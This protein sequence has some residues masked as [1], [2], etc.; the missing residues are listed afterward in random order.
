MA[1]T[2]LGESISSVQKKQL[3]AAFGCIESFA[4]NTRLRLTALRALDSLVANRRSVVFGGLKKRYFK[5]ETNSTCSY[6]ATV[7][8]L[9]FFYRRQLQEKSNFFYSGKHLFESQC[10]NILGSDRARLVKSPSLVMQV[11]Q[12]FMIASQILSLIARNKVAD[13]FGTLKITYKVAKNTENSKT[14]IIEKKL[15][16]I[17]LRRKGMTMKRIRQFARLKMKK[18]EGATRLNNATVKLLN[19]KNEVY[20][21]FF[22]LK[23][24]RNDVGRLVITEQCRTT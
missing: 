2:I 24:K 16:E 6:E 11:S 17:T 10:K 12:N 3:F 7:I 14:K 22:L 21:V 18:M 1:A 20:S 15:E 8:L 13:S 9:N 19:K 23:F 5:G 4:E